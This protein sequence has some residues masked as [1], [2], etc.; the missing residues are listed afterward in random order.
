M[1]QTLPG[2]ISSSLRA[3]EEGY[4]FQNNNSGGLG[5][6]NIP[7]GPNSIDCSGQQHFG[8][9]NEHNGSAN[10]NDLPAYAE[11]NLAPVN[12]EEFLLQL[13]GEEWPGWTPDDKQRQT[14]DEYVPPIDMNLEKR[15]VE[16]PKTPM[17]KNLPKGKNNSTIPDIC[18]SSTNPKGRLAAALVRQKDIIVNIW[19]DVSDRAKEEFPEFLDVY[20]K[21]KKAK[22]P[23][24]VTARVP[25]PSGLHIKEWRKRLTNY[26]DNVLCEY[27]QFGWPLGFHNTLPPQ[28]VNVNHPSANEH[29]HHVR[30]FIEKELQWDAIVGPF[31]NVPFT[32]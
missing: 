27:L 4:S 13:K 9:L 1:G 31:A 2:Q 19:P 18:V 14:V 17:D 15:T 22:A 16:Q 24:F 10:L 3:E 26:H 8:G 29:L 21:I 32:P 5:N 28:S 30:D 11:E 25:I 12:T 7:H 20:Q 6:N 23:N